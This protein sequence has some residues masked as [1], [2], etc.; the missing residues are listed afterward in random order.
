VRYTG[1]VSTQGCYGTG[2]GLHRPCRKSDIPGDSEG[3]TAKVRKGKF[4]M[5]PRPL[6]IASRPKTEQVTVTIHVTIHGLYVA[7]G[8]V[9][10]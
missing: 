3:E 8:V 6:F 10:G 2:V 4:L 7:M 5:G 1:T 9:V